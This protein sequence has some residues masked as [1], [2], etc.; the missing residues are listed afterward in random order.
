MSFIQLIHEDQADGPLAR[1][2]DAARKRA[3]RIY[4]ILKI[5]SQNAAALE[6][7]MQLYVTVM[8]GQSPLSRAQ[9]E[10]LAVVTSHAN[11]CHY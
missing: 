1:V 7:T 11:D 9:R 8:K 2:Y 5:Q 4:N 3:G 6:A 10:M